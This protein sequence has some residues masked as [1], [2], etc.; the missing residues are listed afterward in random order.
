MEVR[1]WEDFGV[2][3]SWVSPGRTVS[4]TDVTMFAMLSGDWMPLHTDRVAARESVYG[5]RV[6]HGLLGL[7]IASGL[8]VRT[9]PAIAMQ[10][11][12][13]ALLGLEWKFTGPIRLD[14]TVHLKVT[15]SSVRETSKPEQGIIVLTRELINQDGKVVQVGTT[16]IMVRRRPA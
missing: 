2:G 6:A 5:E 13:V 9:E 10:T 12:V 4:V 11:T 16:P 8:F 14:D 3:D 1:Y 7:A 15:V